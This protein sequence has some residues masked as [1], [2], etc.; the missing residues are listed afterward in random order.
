MQS[1]LTFPIEPPQG[2]TTAQINWHPISPTILK[3]LATNWNSLMSLNAKKE[4]SKN[5]FA[6][7]SVHCTLKTLTTLIAAKWIIME[8]LKPQLFQRPLPIQFLWWKATTNWETTN[9][10][11]LQL[12]LWSMQDRCFQS[13]SFSVRV[14]LE[15]NAVRP[16]NQ[17]IAIV[18]WRCWKTIPVADTL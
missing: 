16:P 18:T 15:H 5:G 6:S 10:H 12:T 11:L 8:S 2:R 7:R 13:S 9:V 3:P 1:Q 4:R 14:T 17:M